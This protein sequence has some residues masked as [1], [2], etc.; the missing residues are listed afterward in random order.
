MKRR[1]AV[2]AAVAVSVATVTSVALAASSPT[3]ATRSASSV[4]QQS[5]VLNG[6]V[7]PNGSATTYFFQWG[8]TNTY[9]DNS[10]PRSSGSGTK[11]LSV[12][13]TAG[14]LVPGTIYHYRLVAANKLGAT[15]GADRTFKTAGHPPPGVST[16]PTSQVGPN[17]ATVTGVI[18]PNAQ[19]TTWTFQYGLSTAYGSSTFGGSLPA[20]SAP[21]TVSQGLQGLAPATIF[22]YRLV[23][24]HGGTATSYGLDQI[25]MTFPAVR[26]RPRVTRRTTPRHARHKPW[27]FTVSGSVLHPGSIPNQF[28]C[29]GHVGIRFFTRGKRV[30]FALA[31]LQ[32][33][34]TYSAQLV[35]NRK[36]GRGQRNRVVTLHVLTH[37]RGNGYLAPADGR[38]QAVTLR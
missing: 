31:T 11:P 25:F 1:L 17:S 2:L 24:S 29:T 22:H 4:K 10:A 27:T 7:N 34:C 36:P 35:F 32:P 16:G 37:Y 3:V 19:A 6:T 14:H 21:V 15:L 38:V 30:N 28:A 13:A 9:G 5:A 20:G 33:N 8:L 23:G 12:R 18:D 26:P